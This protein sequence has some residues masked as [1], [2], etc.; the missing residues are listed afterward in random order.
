MTCTV[1]IV[2]L[3]ALE[4]RDRG[5]FYATILV[6]ILVWIGNGYLRNKIHAVALNC[7]VFH[8]LCIFLGMI[9]LFIE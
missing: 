8:T 6:F 5:L 2:V 1:K 9:D 7:L 4:P 3:K